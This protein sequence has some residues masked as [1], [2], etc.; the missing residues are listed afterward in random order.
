MLNQHQY[1]RKWSNVI[2]SPKPTSNAKIIQMLQFEYGKYMGTFHEL[3]RL[4]TT[5][6]P[7]SWLYCL[8]QIYNCLHMVP[9]T[10]M[11]HT[12]TNQQLINQPS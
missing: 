8:N 6:S 7:S 5:V 10:Y 2:W 12:S 3:K 11:L 1:P 4:N 9:H